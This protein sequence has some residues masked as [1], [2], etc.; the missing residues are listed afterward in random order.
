MVET[1]IAGFY[2][3][4]LERRRAH[5]ATILGRDLSSLTALDPETMSLALADTL[6]ENVVGVL[7][8]PVGLGLNLTVN[9]E[10]VLV[11]MAIEEPSVIAAFSHAAKLA[12]ATGG[13]TAEADAS[14]M[15]GQIQLCPKNDAEAD[16]AI[17]ALELNKEAILA[18]GSQAAL[19]ISARGGGIRGVELRKLIDPEGGAPMIVVHVLVD[20]LDA[21]GANIVN[22]IAEAVAPKL[23][24]LS[25]LEANLRILSNLCA[26]RLARARVRYALEPIGG[27]EVGR[28]IA[29]ADRFARL[30]PFR[31]ATH[32]KGLMNGIDAVALATG[33][34]WRAIEAGAH[35]WAA[36]DGQYRGL[37]RWV[38]EGE[39][40]LGSIELPL[41][42]GTVGGTTRSHPTIALLR[43]LL[44][45]SSARALAGVLAAVG[46]AQNFAALRALATEGIQR[47]HMELHNRRTLPP[48]PPC[49]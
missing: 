45:V 22:H 29:E 2:R 23:C 14:L 37:T 5:L 42:V 46:L 48:A 26:N 12:R 33:N 36:R 21:M 17:A 18:A 35:A 28:R 40:L 24:E 15:I 30:D 8:I 11:P 7:G 43:E 19:A 39:E 4:P 41:A 38:V 34:D 10:D 31:A 3:W 47:G 32:N 16:R 13:F 27:L 44:G 20:V 25:G 1:R 49:P 6:V 9:G